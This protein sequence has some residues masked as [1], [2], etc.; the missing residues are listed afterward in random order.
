MSVAG[1]VSVLYELNVL[2]KVSE[3]YNCASN[4]S[5]NTYVI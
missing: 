1:E 5:A 3:K 2:H 4:T